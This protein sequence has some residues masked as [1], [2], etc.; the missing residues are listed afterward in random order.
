M[1]C[2]TCGYPE[3]EVVETRTKEFAVARKRRCK[4]CGESWQTLE[5]YR[6]ATKNDK[7][8]TRTDNALRWG[9]TKLERAQRDI[10]IASSLHQGWEV[11]AKKFNLTKTAVYYAAARGRSLMGKDHQN[12]QS[13]KKDK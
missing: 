6:Q 9:I 1:K 7:V 13:Y 8:K 10:L 5:V 4:K 12:A 3:S 2:D 11:L